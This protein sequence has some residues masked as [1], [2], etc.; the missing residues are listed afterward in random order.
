VPAGVAAA[1]FTV[2]DAATITFAVPAGAGDGFI[3]VATPAGTATS[4]SPFGLVLATQASQALPGLAVFPNP[5]SE[6]LWVELPQ[7]GP[8]TVALR[9]LV[10]RVV[11]A[12]APLVA[13][14]AL[15]LPAQLAAGVYLLEVRQGA[16]TAVRRIEKK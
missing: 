2:V 7:G 13:H 15:H 10:G 14:Q 12:P 5:A 9:D 16:V 1:G 11:L 6:G 4:S 3:A 8:A